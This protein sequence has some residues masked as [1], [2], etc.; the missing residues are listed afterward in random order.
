MK[1]IRGAIAEELWKTYRIIEKLAI[2]EKLDAISEAVAEFIDIMD[3][4]ILYA[5]CMTRGCYSVYSQ[6]ASDINITH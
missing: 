3:K 2:I 1:V 5:C 4:D 6:L